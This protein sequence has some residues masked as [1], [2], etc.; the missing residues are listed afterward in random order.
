M[1]TAASSGSS[2]VV[3]YAVP[4]AKVLSIADDLESGVAKARY[5]YGYPAFLGVGLGETGTTV[6]GV[7]QGTPGREGRDRRR[8]HDHRDRRRPGSTRPTELR[9]R[10]RG[11]LPRRLGRRHLDR[12]GRRPRTPRRS[13]SP[14]DRWRDDRF[15][16]QTL[17]ALALLARAL[18]HVHGAADEAELL[19]QPALDVAQVGRLEQRRW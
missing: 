3:G 19:A 16:R 15:E 5:D 8:R 17:A 13:R 10:R 4:I 18:L 11:P 7:Y 1:T 14:R 12:R 9:E 2:D 6:Q